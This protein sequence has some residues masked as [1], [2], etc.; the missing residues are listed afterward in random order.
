M[1]IILFEKLDKINHLDINDERARHIKKIL[2]LKVK[3][4]FSAGVINGEKGVAT[5]LDINGKY[6]DFEFSKT[7]EE[8][9]KLYPLTLLISYVRPICMKRIFREAVSLGVERIVLFNGDL[10]EKSY[11]KANFY[12]NKEYEKVLIDGAMQAAQT[13]IS[14]VIIK[15][16]L[17]DALNVFDKNYDK[18]LL[19]NVLKGDSLNTFNFRKEKC[20]IAIGP[21]RGFSDRER[22]LFIANDFISYTIGKRVLRSET[23]AC[24]SIALTLSRMNLI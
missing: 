6:I 10:T 8:I 9:V 18:V 7:D 22:N 2:K 14:E 15:N 1:N 11:S 19:D 23:A 16:S 13:P 17:R 5:I 24:A 4:S 12:V 21:E 3:D 20:V